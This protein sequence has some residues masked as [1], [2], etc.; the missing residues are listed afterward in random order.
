MV[1]L[2]IFWFGGSWVFVDFSVKF[3]VRKLP[4]SFL[5][6]EV[7]G[8]DD[9]RAAFVGCFDDEVIPVFEIYES[10]PF[11]FGKVGKFGVA[12]EV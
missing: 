1:S 11:F 7:G 6:A 9:Y 5:L 8:P 12:I 4:N 2:S 3:R 10:S